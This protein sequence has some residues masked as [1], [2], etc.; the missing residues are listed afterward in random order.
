[1]LGQ[2]T[3]TGV[4]TPVK[5]ADATVF[6]KKTVPDICKL[7]ERPGA[8]TADAETIGD[9]AT[10]AALPPCKQ[11]G[12]AAQ[13]V[14]KSHE[15]R[16]ACSATAYGQSHKQ[17]YTYINIVCGYFVPQEAAVLNNM[18]L[19]HARGTGIVQQVKSTVLAARE[20]H[21]LNQR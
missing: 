5:P 16:G 2:L 10:S 20:D 9:A 12:E 8:Y 11:R 17:C 1:M 18:V 21:I 13:C 19:S 6:C 14:Q 3:Y 4:W 7:P 15:L